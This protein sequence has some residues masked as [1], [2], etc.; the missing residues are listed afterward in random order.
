VPG[1]ECVGP[2]KVVD[3]VA[4]TRL[5]ISRGS[6]SLPSGP[7]LGIALDEEKLARYSVAV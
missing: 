2:L 3:T 6:I 5:D 4:T 7:G 1:L